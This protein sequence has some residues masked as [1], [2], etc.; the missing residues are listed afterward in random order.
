MQA[1][2]PSAPDDIGVY[3][4]DLGSFAITEDIP[5]VPAS[6][7]WASGA[8]PA[9]S[10]QS[11][12]VTL[13]QPLRFGDHYLY[14]RAMS[15][16]G[17]TEFAGPYASGTPS[18]LA[19]F[20]IPADGTLGWPQGVFR[21]PSPDGSYQS[22]PPMVTWQLT[23]GAGTDGEV[24]VWD[25]ANRQMIDCPSSPTAEAGRPPLVR[26]QQGPLR[27]A[28]VVLPVPGV[29]AAQLADARERSGERQLYA[30]S[31]PPTW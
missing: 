18:D 2:L 13:A 20:Q 27:D 3:T 15:D 28:A 30:C 5:P 7:A 11:T 6:V 1:S 25:D 22:A 31:P 14:S 24:L 29:G 9:G 23:T 21:T 19:L 10:L 12:A 4:V 16:G 17:F 8:T 26:R